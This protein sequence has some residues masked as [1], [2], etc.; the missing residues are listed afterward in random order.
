[1]HRKT[2]EAFLDLNDKLQKHNETVL[3]ERTLNGQ[4]LS[5]LGKEYDNFK[6]LRDTIP[7]ENQSVGHWAAECPTKKKDN[8][9]I[10]HS[11][12]NMENNVAFLSQVFSASVENCVGIGSWS[13]DSGATN[14]ITPNKRYFISYTKFAIPE[15]I[16]IGKKGVS[17]LAGGQGT[18]NGALKYVLYVPEAGAHLF[19]VKAVAQRGFCPRLGDKSVEIEDKATGQTVM[20]G[21]VTHGLYVLDTCVIKSIQPAEVNFVTLSDMLQVYHE[22][23]GH[24]HKQHI[25][26]TLKQLQV[27]KSMLSTESLRKACYYICFK[28]DFSKFHKIFFLK[29]RGEVSTV[30]E[31]FLN[32][33]KTNGHAVNQFRCDGGREFYNKKVSELLASRERE[34]H[35]V[36]ECARFML[37]PSKLP[38]QL[39][40]EAC[41]TAAYLFNH[42]GMLSTESKPPYELWV[43]LT[44][45]L[46]RKSNQKLSAMMREKSEVEEDLETMS[47]SRGSNKEEEDLDMVSSSGRSKVLS[48]KQKQEEETRMDGQWR[49][50]WL[51]A[52]HEGLLEAIHEGLKPPKEN[53]TWILVERPSGVQILQ[54]RWFLQ[55]KTAENRKFC[56][57]GRLVAE[58]HAQRHGINYEETFRPVMHYDTI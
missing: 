41:N 33:A 8:L 3:S 52:I 4:I 21:H 17:M 30:L 32:E 19:S 46:M 45:L 35:T 25:K 57:K 54:N 29:Q 20:T 5:T 48:E 56:F 26:C 7:S 27:N 23:F 36:L 28:G 24:Q 55:K 11:K 22:R 40:P 37:N 34:N 38:K 16:S 1:M 51:E 58:G 2:A 42:T 43:T 15:K 31:Q 53:N 18:K 47:S 14:H 10:N 12:K 6:D 50:C 13:C 9:R 44:R 49:L 39:W